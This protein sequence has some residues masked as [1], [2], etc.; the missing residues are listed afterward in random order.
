MLL[1]FRVVLPVV[2]EFEGGFGDY[3]G[4][5][6]DGEAVG[7]RYVAHAGAAQG[8][9][10]GSRAEGQADVAGEG[11]DVGAFRAYDADADGP[12]GE[13]EELDI[14]D[15]EEFCLEVYLAA[16]AGEVVGAFSV[17]LAGREGGGHLLDGAV[18]AQEGFVDQ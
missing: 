2:G 3:G 1:L 14:V 18:E 15:D 6:V 17:D 10:V 7:N 8:G 13:V 12:G 11:A 16:L 5:L 4:G 9:E